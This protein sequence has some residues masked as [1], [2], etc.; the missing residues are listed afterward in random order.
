MLQALGGK[1]IS[2][3]MA[4]RELPFNVNVTQEQEK[5]EIE[6][7]RNALIGSLQAYTQAIPQMAASG[8]N[9]S[10]IVRKIAEV[11]KSRQKGQTI[12][13]AIE[14]IFAPEAQQVPPAGAPTQVEQTS[15]APA[16]A[17]V[18]GPT[19]EEGEQ[20]QE[21]P[22]QEQAPNIQSLLSSLTSGGEANASVRTIRRR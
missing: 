21:L 8:Q 18:G 7:M 5:I 10:D 1:L 9:P 19:P 11:I 15:P 14:E 12:E 6:D 20:P 4:M 2:K 16:A 13:D 22:P 3:D 17:P